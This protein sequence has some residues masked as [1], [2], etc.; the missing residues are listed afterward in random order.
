MKKDYKPLTNKLNYTF[1]DQKIL[2]QALTHRSI[3]AVNNER[4]EFLGDAILNITIAQTIFNQFPNEHEGELSHLRASL[5]N[6][7]ILSEIA[8]EL[9]LGDFLILG[10]GEL[11]S[12]GFRRASILADTLEA[13]FAAVF[14]DSDIT[15]SQEVIRA[16]YSTRISNANIDNRLKDPKTILQ[17]YAQSLKQDLPKYK[18]QQIIGNEHDQNFHI[19]C[20]VLNI[21]TQGQG[22]TRRK[23]E[24]D[25]ALQALKKL[26]LT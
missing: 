24:Q 16:L 2:Q 18:L 22:P 8:T 15:H 12:G 9:N 26:K 4:L 11:K 23:A 14:I 6:G 19:H 25:A 21:T 5:V 1:K 7:D 13:I 17:E 20:E 10:Q 3:G